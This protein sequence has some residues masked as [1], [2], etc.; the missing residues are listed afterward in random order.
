MSKSATPKKTKLTKDTAKERARDI[1]QAAYDTKAEN[2]TVL[3]LK[4]ISGF[5]DYFVIATG[6]SDRQV[7]AI[8]DNIHKALKKKAV[9]PL[10]IEGYQEGHWILMDYGSVIVHIFYE[11]TRNFYSLEKL[12]GDAPRVKFRLT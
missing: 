11:E 12:W 2:L 5:T 9:Y 4:K 1:A 7:Q 8:C 3:D 6:T 10:V